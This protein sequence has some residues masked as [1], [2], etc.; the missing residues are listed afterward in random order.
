T[1]DLRQGAL[2]A[3]NG[4]PQPA[5]VEIQGAAV[6][7][8]GQP[9]LPAVSRMSVVGHSAAVFADRGRVEVH[10][11]GRPVILAPGERVELVDGRAAG[12]A[13]I[14]GKVTD[15]FPYE[16]VLHPGRSEE[17]RVGKE[18]SCGEAVSKEKT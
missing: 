17:R 14:A 1:L 13:S 7:L 18:C 16:Q 8:R 15:S 6:I 3:L 9:G 12:P 2:V 10:G 5:R 11:A 4:G